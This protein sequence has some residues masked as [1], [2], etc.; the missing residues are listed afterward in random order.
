MHTRGPVGSLV[1]SGGCVKSALAPL[2][3]CKRSFCWRDSMS[4]SDNIFRR[5]LRTLEI[6]ARLGVSESHFRRLERDGHCPVRYCLGPRARGLPEDVLDSWLMW[7]LHLRSR[8]GRLPDPFRLP[9]WSPELVQ[10]SP[11]RGIQMLTLREVERLVGLRSTCIYGLIAADA[12][13]RPAPLGSW[14][15]RWALHEIDAWRAS[16]SD[17]QAEPCREDCPWCPLKAGP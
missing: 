2:L 8:N 9:R 5:M 12:F 10:P 15:R 14:V 1:R 7:C 4:N 11:V 13:P 17:Y 6:L 16:P 3:S